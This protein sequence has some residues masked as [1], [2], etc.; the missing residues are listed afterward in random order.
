MRQNPLS[1]HRK[2]VA[3]RNFDK[4]FSRVNTSFRLQPPLR[5][6]PRLALPVISLDTASQA[7]IPLLISAPMATRI[8]RLRAD[9]GDLSG[10][11]HVTHAL[12]TDLTRRCVPA[13]KIGR[14]H[15]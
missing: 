8:A 11:A 9:L 10:E 2:F 13:T 14:A 4:E 5:P 12:S 3:S 7:K 15:V 1:P 6:S